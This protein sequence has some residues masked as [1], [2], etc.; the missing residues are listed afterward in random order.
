MARFQTIRLQCLKIHFSTSCYRIVNSAFSVHFSKTADVGFGLLVQWNF[1]ITE[2][3]NL[4]LWKCD[5]VDIV[6]PDMC[7]VSASSRPGHVFRSLS[8]LCA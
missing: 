4:C 1:C 6:I 7:A 8:T 3:R 5:I 2:G